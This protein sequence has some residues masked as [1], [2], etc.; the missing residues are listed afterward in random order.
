MEDVAGVQSLCDL[1]SESRFPQ[2][3]ETL[4]DAT[5]SGYPSWDWYRILRVHHQWTMFQAIRYMLWLA[6]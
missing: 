3:N 1:Q 4:R 6:R 5:T 2:G